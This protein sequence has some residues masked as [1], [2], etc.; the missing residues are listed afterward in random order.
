MLVWD[1]LLEWMTHV[2]SGAWE[3]FREG[4]AELTSDEIDFD[5]QRISRTLRVT[6]SD[7]GH[8]D[9]FVG[10]SRRWH[11]MRPA[12]VGLSG[13]N[14]HLFVG[15]RTRSLVDQLCTAIAAH[16]TTTVAEIIPGLSR[17][18]IVGD[19]AAL[20]AA[21]E[22]IGVEYVPDVA[23][24]LSGRLRSIRS[25]LEAAQSAQE[26]INWS[27][28]S[29]S[30][31]DESWVNERLKRTVREYSNRHGVNRYFVH[32][33]RSGLRE[34][35]KR[36]SVYGAA[37]L[38]GARIAHYSHENRS[39]RVPRW[40]PLPAMYARAACLASGRMGTVT[41]DDI[42]FGN[43]DP[44]VASSLLV[45]LGQGFPMPETKQ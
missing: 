35:E 6:L 39:L 40:A 29:W 42:V 28:R 18:H 17:V 25:S 19:P 14:E 45:G 12:L 36:A 27:V 8:A 16:A 23:A 20:A 21:A 41:G 5:E 1:L 2:G 30:F 7:L 24:T 38:R 9:F 13:G 3:A 10:G 34:I 4:V 32:A 44:L 37:L 22:D 43:I 11:V 15:G 33:G 26:P 31:Q